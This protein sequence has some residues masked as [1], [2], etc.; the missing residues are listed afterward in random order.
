[1]IVSDDDELD[2]VAPVFED[3]LDDIALE[4]DP[5]E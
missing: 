5:E 1:V 3:L 4:R 2:A